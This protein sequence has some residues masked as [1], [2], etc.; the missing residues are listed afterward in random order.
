MVSNEG[1]KFNTL[2]KIEVVEAEWKGYRDGVNEGYTWSN[3][4]KHSFSGDAQQKA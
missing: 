3:D 2:R 4:G 1:F